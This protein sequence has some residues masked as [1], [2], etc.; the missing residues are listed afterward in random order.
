M[1][2]IRK[3]LRCRRG[4][5]AVE[6]ALSIPILIT[7]FVGMVELTAYIEAHRKAL[8]AAQT[9]ADLVAQESSISDA[10]LADIRLA[11]DA[12]M[13][14]LATDTVS[15]TI[16]SVGF[17][18]QGDSDL[19]WEDKE[20][21]GSSVSITDADGLGSPN[22]SVIVV[23][24]SYEYNSPFGFMFESESFENDAFARPRIT[25]RIALNGQV[26]HTS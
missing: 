16:A 1:D 3:L 21:G 25:R 19:L 18:E 8:T 10:T 6:A 12:I 5:A 4:V 13:N 11:A 24:M 2:M 14:P 9:V 20:A 26:D 17:D 22:E 7:M 15:V 23:K